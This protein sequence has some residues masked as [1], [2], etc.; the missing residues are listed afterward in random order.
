VSDDDD[1]ARFEESERRRK[2]KIFRWAA[3]FWGVIAI[4]MR[5]FASYHPAFTWCAIIA[6]LIAAMYAS[7]RSF[8]SLVGR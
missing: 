1:L 3:V 6:L 2:R 7:G 8:T 4:V 5:V